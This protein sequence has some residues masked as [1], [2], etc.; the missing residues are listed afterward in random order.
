MLLTFY[1]LSATEDNVGDVERY[2]QLTKMICHGGGDLDADANAR[3]RL[4]LLDNKKLID[5]SCQR[6][7]NLIKYLHELI[8]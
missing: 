2:V 8:L 1:F 6:L 5:L 3:L 7:N 4:L